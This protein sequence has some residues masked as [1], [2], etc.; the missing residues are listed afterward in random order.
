[1]KTSRRWSAASSILPVLFVFCASLVAAFARTSNADKT[2]H[3][4]ELAGAQALK[5]IKWNWQ[6]IISNW[7]VK[8]HAGRHGYLGLTDIE[9]QSIDIWIRQNE[10]Q[11]EVASALLHEIAHAFDHL[12][13]SPD[14]R[15]QWLAARGLAIDTPWYPPCGG[16]SDYRSGAGDFAESVS[17]T[18]EGSVMKFRSRLGPPPST[19]QQ[20]LIQQWLSSAAPR[21]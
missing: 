2:P 9:K 18:L 11:H 15:A 3:A 12:Y 7:S 13:L 10:T 6:P 8:F 14:M 17:W 4:Y 21:K 16:C 19:S 20:A 5:E 1:M